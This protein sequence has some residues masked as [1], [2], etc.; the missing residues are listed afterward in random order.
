MVR[1]ANTQYDGA[2]QSHDVSSRRKSRSSLFINSHSI[3]VAFL[4]GHENIRIGR[5]SVGRI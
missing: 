2:G 5:K 1:V 3:L 4:Y